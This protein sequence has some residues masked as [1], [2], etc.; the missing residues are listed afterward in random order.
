[1]TTEPAPRHPAHPEGDAD[2]AHPSV[3]VRVE[4]T[5]LP[6][7]EPLQLYTA[8]RERCCDDGVHLPA[9]LAGPLQDRGGAVA[10]HDRIA[11]LQVHEPYPVP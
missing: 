1:M 6:P 11:G 9:N 4:E 10:G 2:P 5:G 8:L 3:A 7:H